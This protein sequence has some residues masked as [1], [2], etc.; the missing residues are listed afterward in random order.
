MLYP[1]STLLLLSSFL[2]AQRMPLGDMKTSC[3]D[4]TQLGQQA[5][6]SGATTSARRKR[7]A[8]TQITGQNRQLDGQSNYTY[9]VISATPTADGPAYTV[10]NRSEPFSSVVRTCECVLSSV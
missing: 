6:C 4:V 1:I 3:C 10:S 2:D 9:Y 5:N 7:A 8:D